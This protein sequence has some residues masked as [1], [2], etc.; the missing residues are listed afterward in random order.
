[1]SGD[2]NPARRAIVFTPMETRRRLIVDAAVTAEEVGYEAVIVPEGWS[3]DAGAVLTEV[4]LRTERIRLVAGVFSIWGRTA[5][6]LA[7]TAATI[8]DISGGRFVLGLGASTAALAEGFHG[9]NF[10][11]PAA[12]LAETVEEVRRLLRGD[13][14]TTP[15]GGPGLRLG[16]PARPDIPIWVA[17]LGPRSV[18]VA[19]R[20]ADAW[21]PAMTPR[22]GLEAGGDSVPVVCGPMVAARE[23]ADAA[24]ADAEQVVG[25]Y[26]TGMGPFYGDQAAALGFD[27]EVAALR[28][29]NPRPKPGGIVWPSAADALLDEL[30]AFGTPDEVQAGLADWDRLVDLTAV[31]LP[32]AS[33]SDTQ[34]TI[35]SAAPC[36]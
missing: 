16:Q 7:M 18:A 14:A 27:L 19:R 11:R 20:T 23:S 35:R 6:T 29:A 36:Q 10:A 26:L 1:M 21:F 5:A 25:W 28:E 13:R 17:A 34:T 12:A 2:S 8:D 31:C 15:S 24:R 32:P 9:V 30:A 4:A 33:E 22:R 3:L